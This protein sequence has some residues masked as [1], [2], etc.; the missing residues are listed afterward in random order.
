VA[1][2]HVVLINLA[3]ADIELARCL[4]LRAV[5]GS[6]AAPKS[7]YKEEPRG[8]EIAFCFDTC[9]AALSF[10]MQC[11]ICGIEYHGPLKENSN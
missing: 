6:L 9:G 10:V 8:D 11:G 2:L 7:T 1:A 3:A 5:W 4:A